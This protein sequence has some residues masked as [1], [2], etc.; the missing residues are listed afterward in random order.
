MKDLFE[1]EPLAVTIYQPGLTTRVPQISFFSRDPMAGDP[2]VRFLP[3]WKKSA[4]D[5]EGKLDEEPACLPGGA[6]GFF[7]AYRQTAAASDESLAVLQQK[8]AAPITRAGYQDLESTIWTIWRVPPGAVTVNHIGHALDLLVRK[9]A[10]GVEL[11]RVSCEA[12]GVDYPRLMSLLRR[13]RVN[14]DSVGAGPKV[15]RKS[16]PAFPPEEISIRRTLRITAGFVGDPAVQMALLHDSSPTAAEE[17]ADTAAPSGGKPNLPTTA[18]AALIAA[19]AVTERRRRGAKPDF[20]TAL[21]VDEVITRVAPD[22]KWRAQ[23]DDIC[24]K[25]DAADIRCPKPWRAKGNKTWC[26][27]LIFE[28]HLVINAISHHLKRAQEHKQSLV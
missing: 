7:A 18:D 6:D 22:G 16:A 12:A 11:D 8:F 23:L 13:W 10:G 21:E 5:G 1:P 26:D 15:P 2:D 4:K 28:R 20:A 3:G 14:E 24:D 17:A 9:S 19:A 27:C 25:L